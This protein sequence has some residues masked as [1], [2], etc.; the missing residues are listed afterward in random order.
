MKRYF[1]DTSFLI[2]LINGRKE[3]IDIHHNIKGKEV[4]GTVCASM[5]C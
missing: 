2:D 4:T 3:A 1:L 5:S